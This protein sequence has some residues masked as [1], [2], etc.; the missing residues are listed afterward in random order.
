MASE[1]LTH[2]TTWAGIA[3]SVDREYRPSAA[4]QTVA[5]RKCYIT[6]FEVF[7]MLDGLKATAM[8]L[9]GIPSW[10]LRLG[11]P[12]FAAPLA[13]LYNQSITAGVVPSQWKAAV[14]KV[15][16]ISLVSGQ[17]GLQPLR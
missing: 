12:V 14:I 3:I 8:G 5:E 7:R 17:Q 13:L 15:L 1:C 6:E 16:G 9:D 4:K 11:A 2:W 10:F